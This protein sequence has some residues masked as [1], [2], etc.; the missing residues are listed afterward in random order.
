MKRIINR[1]PELFFIGLAA[2]WILDNYLG[3]ETINYFAIAVIIVLLFQLIY[4][5]YIVGLTTGIV[6]GLFSGYMIMAVL[7]DFIKY[8]TVTAKSLQFLAYG[9]GIFGVS[10]LMATAMVYKFA[11]KHNK[12]S[13]NDFAPML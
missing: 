4:Q 13:Q 8:E 7:S 2:Y 12:P 10:V 5:K 3:S 11:L 1:I 6:L 9:G